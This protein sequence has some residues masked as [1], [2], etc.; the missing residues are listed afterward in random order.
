[1]H[2]TQKTRDL[3]LQCGETNLEEMVNGNLKMSAVHQAQR[4]INPYWGSAN[5]YG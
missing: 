1:M 3:R 4:T 5:M 2:G